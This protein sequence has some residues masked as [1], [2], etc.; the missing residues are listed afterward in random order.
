MIDSTPYLGCRNHIDQ[1]A[2]RVRNCNLGGTTPQSFQSEEALGVYAVQ[3]ECSALRSDMFFSD[4]ARGKDEGLVEELLC[5][6]PMVS[7]CPAADVALTKE[8]GN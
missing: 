1:G 5:E 8:C 6:L 2:R 7:G 3:Q 4:A